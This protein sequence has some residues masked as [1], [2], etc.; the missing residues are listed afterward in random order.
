MAILK[1]TMHS[2]MAFFFPEVPS[3]KPP[4]YTGH[5]PA[6]FLRVPGVV[7]PE[8]LDLKNW[9]LIGDRHYLWRGAIHGG[10]FVEGP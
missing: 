5:F 7:G 3:D 6:I 2:S 10:V 8:E 1:S 9:K 4:F